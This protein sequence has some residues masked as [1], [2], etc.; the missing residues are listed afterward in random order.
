[1]HLKLRLLELFVG[2]LLVQVKSRPQANP[3]QNFYKVACGNWSSSHATDSY[4]SFMDQ[5]DYNYQEKLADLLDNEREDDEPHFVQQLRA[6]YTACRKP[7]SQDQVLRILEHLIAMDNIQTEQ[8]TVGLT[9]AFRLKV[10]PDINDSNTYDIW[11]QLLSNGEHWDTHTTNREP[12]TREIFDKLWANMPKMP[13]LFKEYYWHEMS[14]LEDKIMSYGIKD[15]ASARGDLVTGIPSFWMMPWPN[16]N[17]TYENLF[18]I[19]HFLDLKTD[20]FIVV[21]IYMRLKLVPEGLSKESWHIDRDQCA[22]QSRQM[23]S[24]P[25]VWLVE[26]NHP[27]LKEE[28]VLQD[29]FEELK[30]RFGQKLLA[31]RNNFTRSTQHFLLGKLKRMRL[32]LSILPRN[33]TAQSMVRRIERHYRDVHMNASD[34]FGNLNIGL[35]H[36]RSQRDYP[37]LWAIVFG[38][39]WIPSRTSKSDLYRT[40]VHG[41]GTFASAFYI[42]KQN[43]LIVPLSLLEPPFYTHGQPAIL[44]YSSLGFILGHELSHGFDSQG[45]TFSSNGVDNSAVDTELEWNPRF[46]QKLDCLDRRFSSRRY[47]K[48]ADASGLE[49]AYSAYFDTAQTDHKRKRSAEELVAQKQQ[50][51][52][53]FAQYFCS[54]MELDKEAPTHG[55]D[56]KRVNDAVAHFEPFREAF[57]C[58]PSPRRR[59]CRLY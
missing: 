37:E 27:R 30:H 28:P 16:G 34:Y 52:L 24:H 4:Q 12:L 45:M 41:Y 20:E 7:L 18:E 17:I 25:A 54:N 40:Q 21:Y 1:M 55:S 13:F 59:Q 49:L 26:K 47:E 46:Q 57:S 44:T 31:N 15:D 9:A 29:I 19:A 56:R 23:L 53:N 51:F 58:G 48:F 5:L 36:S 38:H 3:C 10:L 6:F 8:L 14:E 43:M 35:N 50:F 33:C 2:F 32:R 39:E 22:E 42:V 11:K